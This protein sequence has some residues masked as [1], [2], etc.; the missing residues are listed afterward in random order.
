MACFLMINFSFAHVI[1]LKGKY[2]FNPGSL[3]RPSFYF[4]CLNY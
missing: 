4:I 2:T 3:D 1:W